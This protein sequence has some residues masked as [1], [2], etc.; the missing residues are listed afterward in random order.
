MSGQPIDCSLCLFV[1]TELEGKDVEEVFTAVMSPNSISNQSQHSHHTHAA[2]GCKTHTQQPGTYTRTS[3][4]WRVT[5]CTLDKHSYRFYIQR[6]PFLN[7]YHWSLLSGVT[8][9]R[10]PLANGLTGATAQLSNTH[11]TIQGSLAY[12]ALGVP[13]SP[14]T[15]SNMVTASANQPSAGEGEQDMMSAA[16]RGML[17][18]E[19]EE[20]LG[21]MATVAPVLYCNTNFPQLREQYPGMKQT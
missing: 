3:H 21:E 8:Y 13:P 18:W 5:H 17:K 9:P 1:C 4:K 11:G 6:S 19:K 15:C 20:V 2:A 12:R 16:Q 7:M 14:P 10:L